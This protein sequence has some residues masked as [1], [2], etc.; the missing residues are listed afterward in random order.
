[1]DV[2]PALVLAM[3]TTGMAGGAAIVA[4]WSIVGPG[5]SR[6][7]SAV[8]VAVGGATALTG[9]VT[10]G[11]IAT[12]AGLGAGLMA[13][14]QRTAAVLFAVAALGHLLVAMDEGGI[15][16]AITG[17]LLLGGMTSVMLLGH[18]FLVDPQLPRWALQRLDLAAGV[19][20]GLDV[21]VVAAY[22]A[23]GSGDTV[24]VGAMAALTVMTALLIAAVWF[25]LKE[26]SYSGVMA[27]TGLSYLGVLTTFGAVV[28]GRLLVTGL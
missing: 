1:M 17:T 25:S 23:F 12:V 27:A 26:Q 7:L 3:W 6:L 19:G 9:N 4:R 14:R 15:V 8:V 2:T 21:M 11:V 22:G 24:M 13:R 18:W 16:Q 5:Y 10:I 28:V 20:L